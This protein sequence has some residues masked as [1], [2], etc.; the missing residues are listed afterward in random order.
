MLRR[1]VGGPTIMAAQL[2]KVLKAERQGKVT[3]QVVPFNIGAH[4]AQ[5][6]NFILFEFEETTIQSPVV[7]VEGL[8]GNQYL[9][10]SADV[11]RYRESLE[12]LRDSA[13]NPRDSI[14]LVTEAKEAY[15]VSVVPSSY[16]GAKR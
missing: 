6:S 9:E 16:K 8:T 3:I 12:H 2:D 1:C 14:Q 10:K 7:F 5:D 11:A 13:L 4:A 15:A